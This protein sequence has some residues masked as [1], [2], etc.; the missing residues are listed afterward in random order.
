M[1]ELDLESSDS[2]VMVARALKTR[3]LQG[4]IVA[5]L[6]TDFPERFQD[7][8][9]LLAVSKKGEPRELELEDYWFHQDRIVLKF[10]GYDDIEA[11]EQL[12]GLTFAIPASERVALPEDQYYDWE[13][14]GC[15]VRNRDG[16]EIGS[17]REVLKTGGVEILVVAGKTGQEFLIPLVGD[18]VTA[19]DVAGKSMVID[20][21]PGLLDL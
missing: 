11:A 15:E 8:K 1:T 21:P 18:I 20:P 6:L 10:K 2:L 4:E 16:Q 5:E 13:L 19:I 7:L 9:R 12:R 3:G 14:E 17:V